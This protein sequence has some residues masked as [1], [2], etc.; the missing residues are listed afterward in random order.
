LL[1]LGVSVAIVG[2]LLTKVDATS[3]FAAF[4]NATV[5]GVFASVVFVILGVIVFQALEIFWS[6]RLGSRIHIA[7]LCKINFSLMFYVLFLPAALTF[8][9]RWDKYRR[10]GYGGYDSAALVGFHKLLQLG[11]AAA[12]SAIALYLAGDV[13][14]PYTVEL[15]AVVIGATITIVASIV[16]L[17]SPVGNQFVEW[18]L[19]VRVADKDSPSVEQQPRLARIARQ[20]IA[21]LQVALG[22]FRGLGWSGGS[23]VLL[24]A[25]LQ[26][27]CIVLSTWVVVDMVAP[28]VSFVAVA[29]VRSITVILLMLP[30]SVGGLGVRELV[31]FTLF[32][33]FGV[34]SEAALTSSLILFG[35][36]LVVSAIGGLIELENWF[37]PKA[38]V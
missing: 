15:L 31:F 12:A 38:T 36:Q 16:F 27:L 28:Q 20:V 4:S 2:Y 9:I 17:F 5:F 18:C 24:F 26:H 22:S 6:M 23:I 3:L 33:L 11:V 25:V 29:F 13:F 21:K 35:V 7:E 37:R 32:P 34:S 19:K 1:K 30:V 10:A 8:I 14:G